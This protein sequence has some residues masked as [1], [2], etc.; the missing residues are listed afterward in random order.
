M[1]FSLLGEISSL[2]GKEKENFPNWAPEEISFRRVFFSPRRGEGEFSN[3]GSRMR[4]FEGES[5][6]P[7]RCFYSPSEGDG[8]IDFQE[9]FPGRREFL[10]EFFSPRRGEGYF[11]KSGPGGEIF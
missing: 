7:R 2:L 5:S 11:F 6:S 4:G 8:R 1:V 3:I 10:G 9:T